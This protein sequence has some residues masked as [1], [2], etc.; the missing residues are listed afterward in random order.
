MKTYCDEHHENCEGEIGADFTGGIAEVA[1]GMVDKKDVGDA[2]DVI[3]ENAF[4]HCREL[5]AWKRSDWDTAFQVCEI[6]IAKKMMVICSFYI[7]QKLGSQP[8]MAEFMANYM[9][10]FYVRKMQEKNEKTQ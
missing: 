3:L 4:L 7:M 2:I 8:K 1:P 6:A 10:M 5:G 9:E